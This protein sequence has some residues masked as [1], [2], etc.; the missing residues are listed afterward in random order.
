MLHHYIKPSE[1]AE[2]EEE[3]VMAYI[4]RAQDPRRRNTAIAGVAVIHALIGYALLTGLGGTIIETIKKRTPVI[5]F[6]VPPPE[7]PPPSPERSAE[8]PPESAPITVPS[9]PI[10]IPNP[11]VVDAVPFDPTLDV[12]N[13]V[14]R[15][16]MPNLAPTPRPSPA[17][18]FTP[19]GAAPRN[20]PSGWVRTEDY[21]S[22]PLREGAEGTTSFRLVIGSNGRVNA[23]EVTVS[24]GHAAL[25]EATCKFV[26]R[27]ARFEPATD[28]NGAKVVGSYSSKVTWRIPE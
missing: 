17:P 24:S 9:P 4:D 2:S 12:P 16:P 5:E 13:M 25:D 1:T 20:D 14:D 19:K 15:V 10:Q 21:P 7:P 8:T 23:C 22:R 6:T 28:G 11:P 27:R 18:S 3:Y 26:T